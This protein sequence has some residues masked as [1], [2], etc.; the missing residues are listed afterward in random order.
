MYIVR[1]TLSSQS[2]PIYFGPVTYGYEALKIIESANFKFGR[3]ATD[4]DYFE[5]YSIDQLKGN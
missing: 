1:V 5:L 2:G 3:D 4:F